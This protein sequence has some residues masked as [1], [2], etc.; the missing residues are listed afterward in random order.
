MRGKMNIQEIKQQFA[1]WCWSKQQLT[2][3][4]KEKINMFLMIKTLLDKVEEIEQLG[5]QNDNRT[6]NKRDC[7]KA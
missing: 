4:D 5:S 1:K 3:Q 2:W 7:G 6:E